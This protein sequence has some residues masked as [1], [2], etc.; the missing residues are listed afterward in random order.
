MLTD[1]Q[2]ARMKKVVDYYVSMTTPS[3][4]EAL[5]VGGGYS[6][7]YAQ[8]CG[9]YFRQPSVKKYLEQRQ[10]EL[11]GVPGASSA[12][13]MTRLKR[14][15]MGDWTKFVKVQDDGSLDYDFTGATPEDLKLIQ[16]L[17]V[18]TVTQ[19]NGVV[20]KKFKVT[21]LDAIRALDQLNRMMGNF[22]DKL[23]VFDAASSIER[24]QRGR[25]RVKEAR[26]RRP[27]T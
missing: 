23:E 2:E 15:G 13:I 22:Q 27:R 4:S 19:R 3:R 25:L 9:K 1:Q 12:E 21:K 7:K 6:A 20:T 8:S 17:Q 10:R 5:R 11:A 14:I 26:G 24:L 16:E 18:E